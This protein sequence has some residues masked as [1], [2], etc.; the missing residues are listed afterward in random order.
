MSKRF[1]PTSSLDRATLLTHMS[2]AQP[3]ARRPE[4]SPW[5]ILFADRVGDKEDDWSDQ[6]F[7]KISFLFLSLV[8]RKLKLCLPSHRMLSGGCGF[9]YS[10]LF[11]ASASR[12]PPTVL[13]CH[14]CF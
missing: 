4:N 11:D 3:P 1:F 10:K 12:F 13:H 9:P 5:L 2:N 14:F 6:I 7:R 8:N